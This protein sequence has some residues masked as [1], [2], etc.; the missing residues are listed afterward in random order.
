MG[1]KLF[2][3]IE[4]GSEELE[5]IPFELTIDEDAYSTTGTFLEGIASS[6]RV[7]TWSDP[8]DFE[9]A[10]GKWEIVFPE[11]GEEPSPLVNLLNGREVQDIVIVIEYKA[12]LPEWPRARD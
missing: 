2:L 10:D 3:V 6:S 9:S 7:A 1:A 8:F 4:N 5:D 11:D 12:K